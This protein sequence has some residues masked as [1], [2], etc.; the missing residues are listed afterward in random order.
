MKPTIFI[1]SSTAALKNAT[2]LAKEL[3]AFA[4]PKLWSKGVFF[5]GGYPLTTLLKAIGE[6]D[7]GLFLFAR[8][9]VAHIQGK[10]VA[11][12]RDN[13]L[14]EFGMG[15][16]SLGHE[17]NFFMVPSGEPKLHVPSDLAGITW[18]SYVERA[19]NGARAQA[20]RD[21]AG[22]LRETLKAKTLASAS[23]EGPW[24]HH[25]QTGN[26]RVNC[27]ATLTHLG[28]HIKATYLATVNG[29]KR[30]YVLDGVLN[31][32]ML[33]GT[34]RDALSGPTYFGSFQLLV[35]PSLKA[36]KG[37]WMGWSSKK[38]KIRQGTWT[39]TRG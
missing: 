6:H 20:M 17:R 3:S 27:R 4:K 32:T 30:R 29:V 16:G 21:A 26:T 19:T 34:W 37:R 15:L 36:M 31:G 7:V 11:T 5:A 22:K 18:L 10:K 14:F 35:E 28:S 23:L 9:D 1:A 2:L 24:T 39:W 12:T 25:F 13:V 38:K 8:D 33:T